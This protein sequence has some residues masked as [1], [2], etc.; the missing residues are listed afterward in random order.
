MARRKRERDGD[1]RRGFVRDEDMHR[2]PGV[3]RAAD[4]PDDIINVPGA[5]V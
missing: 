2:M 5:V 4:D 3:R 1:A